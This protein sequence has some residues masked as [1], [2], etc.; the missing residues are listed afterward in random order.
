MSDFED[1]CN[2]DKVEI[3]LFKKYLKGSIKTDDLGQYCSIT[4]S[5]LTSLVRKI[6]SQDQE[7]E[8]LKRI[9]TDYGEFLN[10]VISGNGSGDVVGCAKFNERRFLD[11]C[12]KLIE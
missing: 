1:L 5:E 9:K 10:F 6:I 4:A 7:N 8:T 3:E 12:K 2:S 11:F